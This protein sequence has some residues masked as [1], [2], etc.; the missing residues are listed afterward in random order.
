MK[1]YQHLVGYV[2]IALAIVLAGSIIAGSI[3][4]GLDSIRSAI[5]YA[6]DLLR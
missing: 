6:A 5:S 1:E 4:V 3:Q 2:L